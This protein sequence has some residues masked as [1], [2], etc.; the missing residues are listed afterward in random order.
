VSADDYF[1]IQNLIYRYCHLID[2]GDFA[3][4]GGLFAHADIIVPAAAAPVRGAQA[5][6][7]M[8]ASF[9]RRYPEGNTPRTAHV[10]SNLI[11]EADGA[12]A[13]RAQS[14]FL[15]HQA[16]AALPLQP[17]IGGRY[18]DR[19]AR[20]AGA[21]RFSERRIEISLTGNLSA[22]MLQGIDAGSGTA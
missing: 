11:I 13:A 16:T 22:H 10:T 8:Y 7:D 21:W 3:G 18:F 5:I 6:H 12:D 19:L 14:Y 2:S 17:I 4:V 20:V 15:V 9:T 1:A